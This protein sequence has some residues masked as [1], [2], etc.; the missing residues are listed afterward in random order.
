E[1]LRSKRVTMTT[2]ADM[3]EIHDADASSPSAALEGQDT[4]E[5][6]RELTRHLNPSER[7]VIVGRYF[8]EMST[9][10]LI[11]ELRIPYRTLSHRHRRA[12]DRLRE[13]SQ[14]IG[15]APGR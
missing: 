11:R 4:S 13:L 5:R 10:D 12:L 14:R 7:A 2:L 15:L 8:F 3:P 1:Y 6:L 9:E